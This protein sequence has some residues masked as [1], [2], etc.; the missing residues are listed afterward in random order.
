LVSTVLA[1]QARRAASR[2]RIARH[3]TERTLARLYSLLAN[4]HGRDGHPEQA[5]LWAAKAAEASL[6][7]PAEHDVNLRR[8]AL[9]TAGIPMAVRAFQSDFFEIR[10]LIFHPQERHLLAEVRE[11]D[12][13]IWDLDQERKLSF[14][15]V[16]RFTAAAW[17]PEG[18]LLAVAPRGAHGITL[19]RFPE[20]TI[21]Q[22]PLL[23]EHG[24]NAITSLAFNCQGT[25]LASGAGRNV[26][27]FRRGDDGRFTFLTHIPQTNTVLRIVFSPTDP[28]CLATAVATNLAG[29]FVVDPEKPGYTT[30][31]AAE[32]HILLSRRIDSA[33]P[34]RFDRSGTRLSL[35][36]NDGRAG[37]RDDYGMST[38]EVATGRPMGPVRRL[39]GLILDHGPDGRFVVCRHEG[40]TPPEVAGVADVASGE[41][42]STV[43]FN[44]IVTVASF[45]TTG[46][47]A[48]V[49]SEDGQVLLLAAPD[50]QPERQLALHQARVMGVAFAPGGRLA[51]TAQAGGLIRIWRVQDPHRSFVRLGH[52]SRAVLS[53]DGRF[54]AL[55]GRS[56]SDATLTTSRV[57]RTSDAEPTGPVLET[58]RSDSHRTEDETTDPVAPRKAG[59]LLDAVF[60]PS[61]D[62]LATANAALGL[63]RDGYATNAGTLAL[64]NWRT[65]ER[66]GDPIRTPSEPRSLAWS[67]DGREIAVCC[68]GGQFLTIDPAT[69][70]V[71]LLH[72]QNFKW[73]ARSPV[74]NGEVAYAP[75]GT[76]LL[77]WGMPRVLQVWSLLDGTRHH[78][79]VD[80]G[81]VLADVAIHPEGVLAAAQTGT[82]NGNPKVFF[83]NATTGEPI[84]EPLV[85]PEWMNSVAFDTSGKLLLTTARDGLARIWDWRNR[86]LHCPPIA[87]RG[88]VH[89]GRFVPAT[90]YAATGADRGTFTLLDTRTGV[91]VSS[92][93][94]GPASSRILEIEIT[95]DGRRAVFGGKG[96]GGVGL[97]ALDLL[98][99]PPPPGL[100][101]LLQLTSLN[102]AATVD[103]DNA[104]T[105]MTAEEWLKHWNE[106]RR[107]FPDYQSFR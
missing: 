38:Y 10:K 57:Y 100:K 99:G 15:G 17:N 25:L 39:K 35:C 58:G 61:G 67:P 79:T 34:P 66:L 89:A 3:E 14:G 42:V 29:L 104:L 4:N 7:D 8:A 83:Q 27:L 90:P 71:D 20:G 54:F 16:D 78:R 101:G 48:L 86:T 11:G 70:R 105:P 22:S 44:R 75:A 106:F 32:P 52:D 1:I 94:A 92:F 49:G 6:D 28:H 21:V 59:T 55:T 9:W 53:H 43:T 85:Q 74:N 93:Q 45:D 96:L 62:L 30:R 5:A 46:Q 50:W 103:R 73:P 31:F 24:T 23:Q 19:H 33:E 91:E 41:E 2:E 72:Q 37:I 80:F 84:I 97:V 88:S 18:S 77:S 107:D 63:S 40:A 26:T 65:G 13:Q 64:W 36:R 81:S 102:A 87:H 12:R 51:A 95:A 56:A 68:A 76:S 69:R 47:R 82:R 98:H 60:D